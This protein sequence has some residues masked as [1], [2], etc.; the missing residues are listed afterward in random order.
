MYRGRR[1]VDPSRVWPRDEVALKG[2]RSR[3]GVRTF[4][5]ARPV[6]GHRAGVLFAAMHVRPRSGSARR[7]HLL[8][9][10]LAALLLAGACGGSSDGAGSSVPAEAAT[11]TVATADGGEF[12]LATL[13]E[14]PA[15]VWFWAPW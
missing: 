13:G 8:V 3:A 2:P 10:L 4:L 12:D 9:A 11:G 15:L 6:G 5:P 7:F 14:G 1:G